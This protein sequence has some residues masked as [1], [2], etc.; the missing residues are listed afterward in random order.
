MNRARSMKC[1]VGRE[2]FIGR[3]RPGPEAG[4]RTGQWAAASLK[5]S[6]QDYRILMWSEVSS[7]G[8]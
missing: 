5:P 6:K 4:A 2:S 7:L 3:P 8:Q 1:G